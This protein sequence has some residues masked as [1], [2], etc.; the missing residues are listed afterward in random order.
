MYSYIP[1]RWCHYSAC[2]NIF[3]DVFDISELPFFASA[4][5]LRYEERSIAAFYKGGLV[6]FALVD[7][8]MNLRYICAH[9]DFQ[10]VGLGSKL[11]TKILDLSRDERSIWLTTAGDERLVTWYGRYGF[12][13]VDSTTVDG[14]FIGADMVKRNRC[15]SAL[16]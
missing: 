16:L 2:K 9:S 6:G 5:S 12:R 13:V 4:W 3:E 7:K 11:L 10:N 14:E 15:R 1:L 8:K